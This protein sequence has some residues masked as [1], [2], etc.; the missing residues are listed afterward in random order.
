MTLLSFLRDNEIND[1]VNET[2][3]PLYFNSLLELNQKVLKSQLQTEVH[4]DV[5]AFESIPAPASSNGSLEANRCNNLPR[6]LHH[7]DDLISKLKSREIALDNLLKQ[8]PEP[9]IK[10]NS[11]LISASVNNDPVTNSVLI[12]D[13]ILVSPKAVN[14]GTSLFRFA[15]EYAILKHLLNLYPGSKE[16]FESCVLDLNSIILGKLLEPAPYI[17]DKKKYGIPQTELH[18]LVCDKTTAKLISK[19]MIRKNRD[20]NQKKKANIIGSISIKKLGTIAGWRF[21]RPSVKSLVDKTNDV[22]DSA[23]DSQS[24]ELLDD[25]NEDP[26]LVPKTETFKAVYD[27]L[28]EETAKEPKEDSNDL[29]FLDYIK[30]VKDEILLDKKSNFIDSYK[31]SKVRDYKE[32]NHLNITDKEMFSTIFKK[33]DIDWLNGSGEKSKEKL[34]KKVNYC[35]VPVISV[36]DDSFEIGGEMFGCTHQHFIPHFFTKYG[37]KAC[38]IFSIDCFYRNLPFYFLSKD[39]DLIKDSVQKLV[40]PQSLNTRHQSSGT[41]LLQKSSMHKIW[42]QYKKEKQ[43]V[44]DDNVKLLTR[45]FV[46][47]AEFSFLDD[48]EFYPQPSNSKRLFIP[49]KAYPFNKTERKNTPYVKLLMSDYTNKKRAC[50]EHEYQENTPISLSNNKNSN[51]NDYCRNGDKSSDVNHSSQELSMSVMSPSIALSN[52]QKQN[53]Q[54]FMNWQMQ[55]QSLY[56]QQVAQQRFCSQNPHL[57]FS[58][59]GPHYSAMPQVQYGMNVVNST[60]NVVSSLSRGV[61]N[62][63]EKASSPQFLSCNSNKEKIP[64]NYHSVDKPSHINFCEKMQYPPNSLIPLFDQPQNSY[65]QPLSQYNNFSTRGASF[66]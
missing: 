35:I 22:Q 17:P 15:K 42:K 37:D 65:G 56:Q 20:L 32:V 14:D 1:K 33:V 8:F 62:P 28:N 31:L 27:H 6:S 60:P 36:T 63:V 5:S 55:S 12:T 53:S 18:F 46:Q 51:V 25:E 54:S 30:I 50:F 21:T 47:A 4:A 44:P 3:Y 24:A 39:F 2:G 7:R 26:K 29:F 10:V 58:P 19:S 9:T 40:D 45:K 48:E 41:L 64:M 61:L 11:S 52:I 59:I 49:K 66:Y 38:Y 13:Q 16:A 57:T 23:I 34:M 43:K